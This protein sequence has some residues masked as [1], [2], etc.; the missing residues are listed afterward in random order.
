MVQRNDSEWSVDQYEGRKVLVRM[1]QDG[2]PSEYDPK[3]SCRFEPYFFVAWRGFNGANSN[4]YAECSSFCLDVKQLDSSPLTQSVHGSRSLSREKFVMIPYR[5][6]YFLHP[7]KSK[8]IG[9]TPHR[10]QD[11]F[12]PDLIKRIPGPIDQPNTVTKSD[13]KFDHDHR[14]IVAGRSNAGRIPVS[15]L[16]KIAVLGGG[17]ELR[18]SRIKG[19][20][21]G[22]YVTRN[23]EANEVLTLYLGHLFGE[24]QRVH[25]QEAGVGTHCKPL[26]LKHSYL[27]G[28]KKAFIG[29]S[30][31]Q[32]VNHGTKST[33]NCDWIYLDVNPGSGKKVLALRATRYIFPGEELYVN[34]GSKYWDEQNYQPETPPDV[35]LPKKKTGNSRKEITNQPSETLAIRTPDENIDSI[36]GI[37]YEIETLRESLERIES[38]ITNLQPPLKKKRR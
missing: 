24:R 28:V 11:K 32:L 4:E 8:L 27:D 18:R 1:G 29:M 3:S 37:R 7:E 25:M 20:G 38:L 6:V 15:A 21:R 14:I 2:E 9:L 31:A 33:I 13:E 23:F 34:Y 17:I 16:H 5:C 22:L 19:G 30:A 35:I 10:L 12:F 26:Q 36:D